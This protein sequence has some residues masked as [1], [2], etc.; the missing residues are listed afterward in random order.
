MDWYYMDGLKK[1][2]HMSAINCHGFTL[3]ELMIALALSSIVITGIYT[4]FISQNKS[5]IVQSRVVEMQQTLRT[6][7]LIMEKDLRMAGYDP[8]SSGNFVIAS[9]THDS[10]EFG[11]DWDEDGV[12][13]GSEDFKYE[14]YDSNDPGAEKNELHKMSGGAAIAYNIS[15]LEFAY[16]YDADGDDDNDVAG[17]Q[18]IWAVPNGSNWFN[19]DSN[20]DG[21]IDINDT[22]GGIDT[23]TSVDVDD[24]RAVKV[25]VLVR[26]SKTDS[27]YTNTN[28][29]IVGKKHFTANDHY[30]RV[31]GM[32]TIKLRNAGL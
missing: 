7:F 21:E 11:I 1:N 10:F 23:L 22:E 26:S 29:Y 16:A 27:E 31:L 14:L 32:V 25:W 6:V 15:A 18:T 8:S 28:T 30:R 24:I 17:G 12:L 4:T 19:L 5:Y 2:D 9:A 20:N 13:D 3:I